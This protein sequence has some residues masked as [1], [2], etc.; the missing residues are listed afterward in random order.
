ML[1]EDVL[2]FVVADE[3]VVFHGVLTEPV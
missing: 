2:E 3:L 1:V